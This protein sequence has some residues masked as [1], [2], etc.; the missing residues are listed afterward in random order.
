MQ[1]P[2]GNQ[3]GNQE[4][5]PL[6]AMKNAIADEE[7]FSAI[8]KFLL[9]HT[10]SPIW[11]CDKEGK[12]IFVNDHFIALTGFTS[13]DIM[14]KPAIEF[15]EEKYHSTII[16]ERE[17]RRNGYIST[18]EIQFKKKDGAFIPIKMHAYPLPN[19]SSIGIIIDLS[20]SSDKG[21][22]YQMWV[23]S[24]EQAVW[25]ADNNDHCVYANPALCTLLGFTPEEILGKTSV[26]I[27][28][29]AFVK[30]VKFES[31]YRSH[32]KV[33]T[34]ESELVSKTGDRIP[35]RVTANPLPDGGNMGVFTDLRNER[36]E[37]FA[38][39]HLVENMNEAVFLRSKEGKLELANKHFCQLVGYDLDELI[40]DVNYIYWKEE[41]KKMIKKEQA[42]RAEGVSS[43]YRATVKTK[44]NEL[45]PVLVSAS[46]T[47]EGGSFGII[48]DLREILAKEN[49]Y[50]N[51]V[52]YMNEAVWLGN[53]DEKTVY[54]NPKFSELTGYTLE[55]AQQKESFNFL[56]ETSTE[57]VLMQNSLRKRG[58]SSQYEAFLKTKSG[59]KI[60]VLVSGTPTYDGGTIG[61][62]T[63]LREIKRK[64]RQ[65]LERDH[66]LAAVTENSA[67]AIISTDMEGVI[68][69]WNKGS[70]KIFGYTKE[71]TLGKHDTFYVPKE[72]R[73]CGEIDQMNKEI[74][75][76]GHVKDFR[77][78]RLHRDGHLIDLSLTK[79][80]IQEEHGHF[81][82]YSI[83]YRDI[84]LQKK[85]EEELNLRFE[86]LKNAYME[87]GKKGRHIDYF[88]DLLDGIVGD[89]EINSIADFIVGA[90]AMIT[91]VDACTLRRYDPARDALILT[92]TN[93]VTAEWY[94]KGNIPLKGSLVEKAFG[95]KKS[96]K[97]LDLHQE[98]LYKAQRLA[99][100]HNLNSMLVLPLYVKDELLG[101]LT[102]YISKESKFEL[103]DNDFIE[104]FAKIAAIALKLCK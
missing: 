99:M 2:L 27:T 24:M 56:D 34:Y 64:E 78:Q 42:K 87:L 84:S 74:A 40:G 43:V 35:V 55:E 60:P 71:E 102:L 97:V 91:K 7:T 59:E 32:G 39:K 20:H 66:Y 17:R 98:P 101:C 69:S 31:E 94:N 92:A 11:L 68:V 58:Q 36:H 6:Q 33:S 88:I 13:T 72:K 50:Q 52:E 100:K 46:P 79:S 70:E 104:H 19:G 83:I 82:G 38:Y 76:K 8:Y 47:R 96:C 62:I 3:A 37:E 18:Y 44:T 51:L 61:I 81:I 4:S 41:D 5:F 28:S 53:K 95:M 9:E 89:F 80:A 26:D 23:E 57:L 54:V 77:T 45:I 30:K 90:T 15:F 21:N 67:D 12:T 14:G 65:I 1:V 25:A 85:W 49:V 22:A 10:Q 73:D 103:L 16:S 86:N 75:R 63:D 93:G 48:T 29:P